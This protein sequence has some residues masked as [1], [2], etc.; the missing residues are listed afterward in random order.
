MDGY[1]KENKVIIRGINNVSKFIIVDK[2]KNNLQLF[3]IYNVLDIFTM[4]IYLVR[5]KIF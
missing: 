2:N 1:D 4:K 5:N 3:K